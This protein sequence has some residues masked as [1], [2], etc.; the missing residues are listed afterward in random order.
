MKTHKLL[1][2]VK[3]LA[4]LIASL[5][6][7][8]S[9]SSQDRFGVRRMNVADGLPHNVAQCYAQDSS[10]VVWIGTRNG[11]A[12]FD[13]I[14][15]RV[16]KPTEDLDVSNNRIKYLF[17][18]SRGL[19]WMQSFDYQVYL[20]DPSA[21]RFYNP[22][23][24]Q[25]PTQRKKV[26][27]LSGGITYVMID[28]LRLYRFDEN[29]P[30]FLADGCPS[31]CLTADEKSIWA[32][33]QDDEGRE[34]ILCER[35]VCRVEG[36]SLSCI[37]PDRY[38]K[39]WTADGELYFASKEGVMATLAADGKSIQPIGSL[40]VDVADIRLTPGGGFIVKTLDAIYHYPR[41]TEPPIELYH[42]K[43]P[44]DHEWLM[45]TDGAFFAF[46]ADGDIVHRDPTGSDTKVLTYPKLNRSKAE[47]SIRLIHE[48]R[49][50][51]V[52]VLTSDGSLLFY[53]DK[54]D[55]L[56]AATRYE[57]GTATTYNE[58]ARY[59]FSDRHKNLWLSTND[60][61]DLLTF[62]RSEFEWITSDR[63]AGN[64]P[65]GFQ[66]VRC[67][68]E[69]NHCLM[70]VATQ[71]GKIE[72]YDRDNGYVGNLGPG[73]AV[74]ADHSLNFGARV[75]CMM[76]DREQ[77]IFLG[78]RG[79]GI[80]ILSPIS[81]RA[82]HIDHIAHSDSDPHSLPSNDV[83]SLCQ[84]REGR[85]WV[86]TFGKGLC[87]ARDPQTSG[88][89][90]TGTASG[91]WSF[92]YAAN[93]LENYPQDAYNRVR[94]LLQTNDGSLLVAT[95]DGLLSVHVQ[96]TATTSDRAST[97]GCRLS[98][99]YTTLKKDVYHLMQ[100]QRGRLFVST[101]NDGV[102]LFNATEPLTETTVPDNRFSQT[103]GLPT[104]VII[105]TMEGVDGRIYI[106]SPNS[107][108][109]WDEQNASFAYNSPDF[110]RRQITIGEAQPIIDHNGNIVV[111]TTGGVLKLLTDQWQRSDIV[112]HILFDDIRIYGSQP[113]I[114]K[115]DG[116][117]IDIRPSERTFTLAFVAIDY[118]R[119]ADID[120]AYRLCETD[121]TW[122][123][124]GHNHQVNFTNMTPGHHVVEVRSTNGDGVWTD[125]TVAISLYVVPL[126][127]ET[128]LAG[129][130]YALCVVVVILLSVGI[131]TY[132]TRLRQEAAFEN[133]LTE[134]KLRFFTDI[135]HE[136]RTP[137]TLIMG[138]IEEVMEKEELSP[139]G[140]EI[141]LTAKHNVDR[142]L[143]LV[144]QILDFR[145]L[146]HDKMKVTLSMTDVEAVA[147]R[148][149]QDFGTMAA[150]R[151]IRFTHVGD[152]SG[153]T[154]YA[155]VDK[156]E[157]ILFN[158]LSNAFKYTPRHRSITLR[159]W[160]EGDTYLIEVADQGRGFDNAQRE[161]LFQ[162]FETYG[163]VDSRVS[164]GIGL[165]LVKEF[166]HVLHGRIDVQS[167]IGQ[168]STFTVS[169]PTS[170]RT[171]DGDKNVA[172]VM[173]DSSTTTADEPAAE[174]AEPTGE[175]AVADSRDDAADAPTQKV[176]VVE[177][178]DELRRYI[179]HVLSSDYIVIEAADGQEG[180]EKSRAENPDLVVCDVM[181][182]IMDGIEYLN[183][184]KADDETSHIPVLLLTAKTSIEDQIRGME[185]G[186]DDY[187]TK[188]FHTDYLRTKIAAVL[189]RRTALRDYYLSGKGSV[190]IQAEARTWEPK[191]P[192]IT[193]RDNEFITQVVE[194][195]KAHLGDPDFKMDIL[196]SDLCVSRSVFYRK[197]KGIM[198][199]SPID[200]A[201]QVRIKRVIELMEEGEYSVTEIAYKCGFSSSQYLS[202]MFKEIT[203]QTPTEYI[204]HL[205]GGA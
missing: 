179:R 203:G 136:L 9:V 122:I 90:N 152:N 143:K 80:Y 142:M 154:G 204:K 15:F 137:L 113:H 21:G 69:D 202:R 98:V 168:G 118:T 31:T 32:I 138:P 94:H 2:H 185:C 193:K 201:K 13:G 115:T 162:R 126:F 77:R 22:L 146:R 53:D 97:P 95:T 190:Q 132:I 100:D 12:R 46:N 194:G 54:D 123:P 74:V 110:L 159:T 23:P 144:T 117:E 163:T 28:N 189:R 78:T 93:G 85:I 55:R 63:S 8:T 175:Q 184:L 172:F 178:N 34:W 101:T 151:D 33:T 148:V 199:M 156:L 75:Y 169:L 49:V 65:T 64:K 181:M 29:V 70:W 86:G 3:P 10:D 182:P 68:F 45:T 105:A 111:G 153:R 170:R 99:T 62:N 83:F 47:Q 145:K 56:V 191:T 106:V 180:L 4:L 37:S 133:R 157:K 59:S 35:G 71:G 167:E 81:P 103:N 108:N 50:G 183:T 171:F 196:A 79:N 176:L 165:S 26:F 20:F 177:D 141:M 30:D 160:W 91:K 84:D 174:P 135:S 87:L 67:V 130:L 96:D 89:T 124:L 66:H 19:M 114:K 39:V 102:Y 166:V 200:L 5:L 164:T 36:D 187:I 25:L 16:Y 38:D 120:Y 197:I 43:T 140:R 52:W 147:H 131:V 107:F 40:P 119:P 44:G 128:R 127:R 112:P 158:L 129:L 121:S 82:Y 188:P 76:Q 192:Q 73:G 125:N 11:I 134:I 61:L 14:D 48:D 18:S 7:A 27:C 150:E 173:N 116:G 88:G 109:L 186:A 1:L 155:D 205:R 92:A 6:C 51:Q 41:A 195:I 72:I 57:N 104:D 198:G 60:G 42:G 139:G 24:E 17:A 58:Q 149:F 161:R